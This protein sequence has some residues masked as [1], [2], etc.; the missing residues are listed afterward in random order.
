MPATTREYKLLFLFCV[1]TEGCQAF[2]NDATEILSAQPVDSPLQDALGNISLNRARSGGRR[3][4]NTDT[5][6]AEQTP[7]GCR[8]LRSTKYISDGQCTSLSPVK[9]LVC[10]GDCLPAHML[11]NWISSGPGSGRKFWA[12]RDAQEWRCVTDRTRSQ[13]VQ[14]RCPDGSD[15]TYRITVVTACKC[16]RYSRQHNDSATVP[17]GSPR[18]QEKDKVQARPKRGKGAAKEGRGQT[19]PEN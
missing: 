4:S 6:D 2:S 7:V 16:K 8:E 11:P 5:S 14:L 10:A 13:R 18:Q 9:E 15:R 19:Q 17:D 3:L 12:R 1:V